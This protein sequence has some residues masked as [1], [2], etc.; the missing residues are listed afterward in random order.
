MPTFDERVE[1]DGVRC[2][3]RT[4]AAILVDGP[5]FEDPIWIPQSQVD[6][7]SEVWK[8]GQE[9]KLVISAWFAREKGIAP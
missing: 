8:R 2:L 4:A 1:I 6:D 5:E 9:G 7:D 3:H